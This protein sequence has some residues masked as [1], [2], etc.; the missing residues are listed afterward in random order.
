MHR[1][2]ALRG[3]SG[4]ALWQGLVPV[5]GAVAVPARR[6]LDGPPAACRPV[7]ESPQQSHQAATRNVPAGPACRP[8]EAGDREEKEGLRLFS[9]ESALIACSPHY[10]SSHATDARAALATIRDASGLLARLL[11]GGHSTIAGRLAGAFRNS[12]RD[13]IADDIMKTMSAAG[14]D[15][16]E[17]DPFADKPSRFARPRNLSVCEPH[18]AAVAEDA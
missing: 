2:G 3:L 9:L 4:S 17:T 12:G 8:A 6:E 11:E 15:V 16:R 1:S 18:T 10:F 5:A 14:Y 7:A 13:R